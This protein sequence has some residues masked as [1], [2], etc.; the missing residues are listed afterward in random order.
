M[1]DIHLIENSFTTK[2]LSM[3]CL[4][5]L[6]PMVSFRQAKIKKYTT[7]ILLEIHQFFLKVMKELLTHLAKQFLKNLLAGP[8][9]ELQEYGTLKL[10]SVN[11][12]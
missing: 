11:M 8:G 12:Y 10:E 1:G 6:T 7:L 9:M 4:Q 3:Q 5:A 2:V